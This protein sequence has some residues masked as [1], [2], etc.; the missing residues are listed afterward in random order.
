MIFAVS[1]SHK[2]HYIHPTLPAYKVYVN[3]LYNNFYKLKRNK[4]TKPKITK[5]ADLAR[6]VNAC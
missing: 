1:Y 6:C 2:H 5:I 3:R 4:K